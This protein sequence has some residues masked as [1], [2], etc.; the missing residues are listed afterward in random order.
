MAKGSGKLTLYLVGQS[1]EIVTLHLTKSLETLTD[2]TGRRWLD[3][4]FDD[5]PFVYDWSRT[6]RIDV[7]GLKRFL[8]RDYQVL[9]GDLTTNKEVWYSL[10]I[11]G[12]A[13]LFQPRKT[14]AVW[15]KPE[16]VIDLVYISRAANLSSD[17]LRELNKYRQENPSVK[18]ICDQPTNAELAE[19]A[20]W[21]LLAADNRNQALAQI[22]ITKTPKRVFVQGTDG[23]WWLSDSET[24]I[25]GEA[26]PTFPDT[27][28][29][30]IAL[31]VAQLDLSIEDE[32]GL[33]M[34]GARQIEAG[35]ELSLNDIDM[36]YLDFA[37]LKVVRGRPN[38]RRQLRKIRRIWSENNLPTLH[39]DAPN[40][41]FNEFKFKKYVDLIELLLEQDD[42]VKKY[43]AVLLDP[44]IVAAFGKTKLPHEVLLGIRADAGYEQL[45]GFKQ[46]R[47]TAG[48]DGLDNRLAMYRQQ[49]FDLVSWRIWYELS[50]S[51]DDMAILTNS[52][53]ASRFTKTA[54]DAGLVPI[55]EFKLTGD[56]QSKLERVL[57][58][59]TQEMKLFKVEL[60][61]VAL[62]LTGSE[63]LLKS[64]RLNDVVK[65]LLLLSEIELATLT[66]P[67]VRQALLPILRLA[68]SLPSP[69]IV[70]EIKRELV[71]LTNP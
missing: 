17:D 59:L 30:R 68:N 13:K 51:L 37:Q 43:S 69:E 7:V 36:D 31:A 39:C 50:D 32:A 60:E 25:E 44:Q 71:K 10:E 52:H 18:L 26:K 19:M 46:S 21:L 63:A 8:E 20:D 47:I 41:I 1:V 24:V 29:L 70:P 55:I 14:N 67:V 64:V 27:E 2:E 9:S 66:K 28:W 6:E 23:K 38:F 49:G 45:P 65:P 40:E 56:S 15:Q 5:T 12:Q 35:Q 42:L 16:V 58:S 57:L 11:D 33:L 3:L 4:R 22:K 62:M 61:Q 54:Q 48:L 34:A 53:L